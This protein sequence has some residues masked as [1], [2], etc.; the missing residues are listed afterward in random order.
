MT[1]LLLICDRFL[2]DIK[3]F[4]GADDSCEKLSKV[5]HIDLVFWTE[6]PPPSYG[7]FKY[8]AKP[9]TTSHQ[10]STDWSL[11]MNI[12]QNQIMSIQELTSTFVQPICPASS[13]KTWE[14]KT[15]RTNMNNDALRSSP[16]GLAR[17]IERPFHKCCYALAWMRTCS[18][19]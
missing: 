7:W 10:E 13:C 2:P 5:F 3:H 16:F 8:N 1:L 17:G 15:G 14:K 4:K 9:F 11:S 19:Q 18:H 6:T 12:N